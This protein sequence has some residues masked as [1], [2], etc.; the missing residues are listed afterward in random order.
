MCG[1][2]VQLIGAR[3]GRGA[4]VEHDDRPLPG[5]QRLHDGRAQDARQ[6]AQL[7]QAGRQHCTRRA[8]RDG[9]LRPPLAHEA[10]AGDDRGIAALARSARR[11][12]VVED[13]PGG[14]HDLELGHARDER[15]EHRGRPAHEHAQVAVRDR[16]TCARDDGR[17]APVAAHRVERDGDRG[18]HVPSGSISRPLYVLHV[19]HIRCARVGD[20][21][22][23]HTATGIASGTPW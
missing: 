11:L 19:G 2:L 18:A 22:C 9:R 15:V 4:D 14:V 7:E 23:G 21:H 1:E 16:V 5:R 3:I 12:L 20:P 10:H 17:R 6:P 8:R 13:Q